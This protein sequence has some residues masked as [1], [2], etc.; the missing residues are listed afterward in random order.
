MTRIVTVIMFLLALTLAGCKTTSTSS[1]SAPESTDIQRGYKAELL[2]QIEHKYESP[3][4]HY[5]LAKLYQAEGLL[6][7]ADF[8]FRVTIGFDPVHYRAQAGLIK[9]LVDSGQKDT[10]TISA[11]LYISQTAVSAKNSLKLGKAFRDEGL[12][13]FAHTCYFQA[14]SLDPQSDEAFKLL[15]YHYLS[16]KDKVRAEEYFRRSFELNPYQPDVSGEL[17]RMGV[18]ISGPRRAPGSDSRSVPVE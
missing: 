11:D 5:Q 12:D 16:K 1:G 9:V 15:G 13:A 18:I 14:L 7:R 8:E 3:E 2:K 6:D 17:G 10:A 4:A